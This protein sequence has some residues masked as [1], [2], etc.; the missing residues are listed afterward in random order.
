MSEIHGNIHIPVWVKDLA[1]FWRW[2]DAADLPEKLPVHF[3]RREVWVDVSMEEL[4]SHNQ[5]KDALFYTLH[6]LIVGGELGRFVPDGMA[7]SNPDAEL[8]TEPD[9]MFISRATMN[10]KRVRFVAGKKRGARATRVVGTPDLV[11]EIV[12]PNTA[13]KDT[14][15]LMSAYHN[16][17]IPEYWLIDARDD[18]AVRFDIYRHGPK[19]YA[20]GRKADGWVKSAVFRK[21][22]RLTRT[23]DQDGYPRFTL[24][25]R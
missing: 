23:E 17:G 18:S 19:G 5:I 14:E 21:A 9:A 2:R 8:A 4:F 20:A 24:D 25:V 10:A 7:L 22:F 11:I 6:G 1:A 3:I 13:D 16:A 12:S 15:W